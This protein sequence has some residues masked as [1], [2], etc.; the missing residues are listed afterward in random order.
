MFQQFIAVAHIIAWFAHVF[1]SFLPIRKIKENKKKQWKH[2]YW[3][4]ILKISFDFITKS[5]ALDGFASFLEEFLKLCISIIKNFPKK[6][7]KFVAKK[8]SNSLKFNRFLFSVI[9]QANE[10]CHSR[11]AK[12]TNSQH[13]ARLWLLVTSGYGS[14]DRSSND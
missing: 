2:F 6:I 12:D 5:H 14:K 4:K 8:H 13:I 11:C 10:S 1:F 7:G 3:G 9:V